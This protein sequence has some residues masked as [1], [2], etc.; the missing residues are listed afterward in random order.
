[1]KMQKDILK[2]IQGEILEED[3]SFSLA[4]L[5]QMTKMPAETVLEMFDYGVIEPYQ[6]AADKLQFTGASLNRLRCA[7]RL[8]MDLGV[9]TAGAALAV[10]VLE[11]LKQLRSRLQRLEEQ[12]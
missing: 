11:E 9:N 10:E 8:K 2:L 6:A 4:Q 12:L 1:M 5:C 3:I 7:Q